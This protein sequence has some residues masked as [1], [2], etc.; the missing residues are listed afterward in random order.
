M[1]DLHDALLELAQAV[2]KLITREVVNEL[3]RVPA[4][5]EITLKDKAQAERA[6]P[7]KRV[8]RGSNGHHNEKP[9]R[10]RRTPRQLTIDGALYFPVDVTAQ[11]LGVVSSTVHGMIKDGR[12]KG[13]KEGGYVYIENESIKQWLAR[14]GEPPGG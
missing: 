14:Q 1:S 12:I 9:G 11:R 8:A 4:P 10:R 6:V 5:K 3:K 7:K 13:R 2:A